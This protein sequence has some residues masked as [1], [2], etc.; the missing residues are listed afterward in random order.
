MFL[1]H[2]PFSYLGNEILQRKAIKKL[3]SEEQIMVGLFALFFGILPDFDMFVLTFLHIPTFL[4]HDVISHTPIFYIVIW[5]VLRVLIKPVSTLLNKK[6]TKVL[7]NELLCILVD[8]FLIATLLHIFADLLTTDIM[9]F[10]PLSDIRFTVFKYLLEPN[11]FAGYTLSPLFAMELVVLSLFVTT[12]YKKYLAES[13]VISILTKAFVGIASVYLIFSIYMNLNTYNSSYL[14]DSAGKINYDL[15]YDSIVDH[16][17]AQI[18]GVENILNIS[19]VQLFDEA[20]EVVNTQKWTGNKD[21]NIIEKMKY[22]YGGLSSYRLISQVYY[23]LHLPIEAV[24]SNYY[25]QSNSLNEYVSDLKYSDVLLEYLSEKDLMLELN[26][27][28]NPGIPRGKLI[29][30]LNEDGSIANLGITLESNYIATI[31]DTDEYVTMH[32]YLEM[33][34]VYKDISAIY[35]SK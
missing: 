27:D 30:F 9:L 13:L 20:L 17:D 19:S 2:A 29:F 22:Q 6:I 15:D 11:L 28:S 21:G 31:L 5:A 16:S 7:H 18:H 4:H 23:D 34:E 32:S 25:I 33:R 26:L 14:Y 10:Y 12:I 1:A 8:T 35:I 24:L 3:K